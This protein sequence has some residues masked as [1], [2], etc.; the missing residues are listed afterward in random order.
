MPGS[1]LWTLYPFWKLPDL[2]CGK[3][4]Q[5]YVA[6][7]Y[8]LGDKLFIFQ[9]KNKKCPCDVS[10]HSQGVHSQGNLGLDSIIPLIHWLVSL[11]EACEK[12]KPSPHFIWL[13]LAELFKRLPKLYQVFV[14]HWT[15]YRK[16]TGPC[17]NHHSKQLPCSIAFSQVISQA[18]IEGCSHISSAI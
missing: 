17:Q 7:I 15:S 1:C 13:W 4:I 18:H 10:W 9:E 6:I 8:C 5:V 2:A 3:L 12:I 16:H 11:P 14:F